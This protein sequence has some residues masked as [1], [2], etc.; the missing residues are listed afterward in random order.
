MDIITICGN[1]L[2][3]RIIIMISLIT[4]TTVMTNQDRQSMMAIQGPI[5]IRLKMVMSDHRA[6]LLRVR[7][8]QSH[9]EEI[10]IRGQA[11]RRHE[12]LM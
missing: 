7:M 9:I 6:D 10:C 11:L 5:T 2:I 3:A 1:R 12:T 8:F 4:R